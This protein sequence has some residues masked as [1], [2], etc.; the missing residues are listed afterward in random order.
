MYLK[1]RGR[2]VELYGTISTFSQ[3]IGLSKNSVSMKLN[4]KKGFSQKDII[5]W[6]E[7]LSIKTEDIG[8]YFFADG[9][10]TK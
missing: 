6:C 2:I 7:K 4:G 8:S 1:L 10:Q 3:V 9:V 5:H